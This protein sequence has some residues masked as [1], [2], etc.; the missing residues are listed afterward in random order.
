MHFT[1]Q[2]N[3][4]ALLTLSSP[5]NNVKLAKLPQVSSYANV[6]AT[7]I[8]WGATSN[9]IFSINNS[10]DYSYYNY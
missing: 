5:I 7:A 6:Y 10:S 2:A 4:I 9:G 3:D 1:A 8:G